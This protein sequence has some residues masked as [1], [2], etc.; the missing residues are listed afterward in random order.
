M[1]K[2]NKKRNVGLLHEQLIRHASRMT[3]EGNVEK[4]QEAIKIVSDHFK[5]EAQLTKEFKL[6]SS[7]VH[8]R[9]DSKDLAFR[10]VEESRRACIDHD[11]EDLEQIKS[12]HEIIE[13][14]QIT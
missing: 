9:V 13:P 12:H 8:T 10:I 14:N 11:F 7:L 1:A 2:H 4:A 5:Q 6:F 3:V